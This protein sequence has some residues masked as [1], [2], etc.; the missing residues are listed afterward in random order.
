VRKDL[1]RKLMTW[2]IMT[3]GM[4]LMTRLEMMITIDGSRS[5]LAATALTHYATNGD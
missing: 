5:K 1:G 3:T 2:R 4:E